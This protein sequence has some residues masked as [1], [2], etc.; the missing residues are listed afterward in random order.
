LSAYNSNSNL[1]IYSIELN[2][3]SNGNSVLL[4]WEIQS[5][6]LLKTIELQR[7]TT[8]ND[9]YQTIQKFVALKS[10]FIDNSAFENY[11]GLY[12][13]LKLSDK[14]NK[15][16]YSKEVYVSKS[17][18]NNVSFNL[19]KSV[20]TINIK[21]NSRGTIQLWQTDGKMYYQSALNQTNN[22]IYLNNLR[23][24]INI[25]MVKVDGVNYSYKFLN[26]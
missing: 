2:G 13:R 23:S 21:G 17:K 26:N 20:L 6:E 8:T 15:P 10:S 12:Y 3:V 19:N 1:P 9:N 5:D 16:T 4:N 11:N 18:S 25:A 14:D 22:S 7:K 24:G